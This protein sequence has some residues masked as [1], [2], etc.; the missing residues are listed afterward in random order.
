METANAK[1]I[2]VNLRA[3]LLAECD[4]AKNS[5][6][7]FYKNQSISNFIEH[8]LNIGLDRYKNEIQPIE[9]SEPGRPQV[10]R[11]PLSVWGRKPEAE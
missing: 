7:E 2:I 4:R 1:E 10:I 3:G 9:L 8:L 5:G 11:P 6:L